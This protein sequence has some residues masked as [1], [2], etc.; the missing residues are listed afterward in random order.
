MYATQTRGKLKAFLD[1]FS[2]RFIAYFTVE[3]KD[4]F[5]KLGLSYAFIS[6]SR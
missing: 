1:S 5:I 6:S 4:S 3:L 2:K